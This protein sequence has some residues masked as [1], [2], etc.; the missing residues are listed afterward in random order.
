M[1]EGYDVIVV[2]GGHNGVVWDDT[3]KTCEEMAK[4]SKKDAEAF[5]DFQQF[6]QEA[7]A[8][9]RELMWVT[10]PNPTSSQLRDIRSLL[11]IGW[12]FRKLGR[13]AF[14]FMDLMLE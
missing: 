3:R 1:A 4:F 10:P 2:G 6:R 7:A 14:R 11:A 5:P 9:V 13:R 8:F 12:K